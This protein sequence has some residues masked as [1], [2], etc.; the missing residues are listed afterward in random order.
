[1][2]RKIL[3]ILVIILITLVCSGCARILYKA[4]TDDTEVEFKEKE[5]KTEKRQNSNDMA[6]EYMKERYGETFEYHQPWG[7]SY[8]GTH[9]VL[10]KSD[11]YPDQTIIVQI[12]DFRQDYKRFYDNYLLV[13]YYE[14]SVNYFRECALTE[15]KDVKVHY[16]VAKFGLSENT[17]IDSTFEEVLANKD[18]VMIVMLEV[19]ESDFQSETQAENVA[20]LILELGTEYYLTLVVVKDEVYGTSIRDTLNDVLGDGTY[21]KML[22]AQHYEG[23][24]QLRWK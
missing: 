13:K 20:N 21:V 2:K 24:T 18:T 11:K 3:G 10:V 9:E 19:K 4:L 23:E 15:F 17:P 8:S 5:P 1:M 22:K 7:M 16:E 12:E 6:L 14:D